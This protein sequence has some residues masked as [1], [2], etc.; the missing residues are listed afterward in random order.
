MKQINLVE[1]WGV[2]WAGKNSVEV[3]MVG[4]KFLQAQPPIT[5]V[6]ILKE[7]KKVF[8]GFDESILSQVPKDLIIKY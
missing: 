4:V 1:D 3:D 7:T 5:G 8:D 2:I 6:D